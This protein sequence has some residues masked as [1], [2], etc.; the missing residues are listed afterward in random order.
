MQQTQ[1]VYKEWRLISFMA[2]EAG[3]AK[4]VTLELVRASWLHPGVA[5]G[6]AHG[7]ASG[8]LL[9]ET[10]PCWGFSSAA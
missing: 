1:Q 4:D 8:F 6:I 7:A 5:E 10:Q 2:L 3:E 9:V